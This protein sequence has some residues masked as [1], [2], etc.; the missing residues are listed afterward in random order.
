MA[1]TTLLARIM[2]LGIY[3]FELPAHT[4]GIIE[5]GMASLTQFTARVDGEFFDRV[6]M[7]DRRPMAI[8]TLDD[9]MGGCHDLFKILIMEILTIF[10]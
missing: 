7:I 8:L 5:F 1:C 2:F 9:L 3:P 4:G 6:R 10:P